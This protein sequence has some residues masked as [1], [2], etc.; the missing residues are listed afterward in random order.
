VLT[1]LGLGE[2]PEA[3]SVRQRLRC[4]A[5]AL[6]GRGITLQ[7]AAIPRQRRAR[8]RLFREASRAEIVFLQR[9]LLLPWDVAV[10]RRY[11]K[12]LVFDFDDAIYLRDREPFESRLRRW[13]FRAALRAADQVIAGN[14]T[15]AAAARS[16]HTHVAVVPTLLEEMTYP[17]RQ[18]VPGRVLWMGQTST[19]PYL[20]QLAPVLQRIRR[21][22]PQFQLEVVGGGQEDVQGLPP[23]RRIPW[24]DDQQ[25]RS[26]AEAHLG[27]APL[28]DNP[29]TRGKC[30]ARLLAY[31][32][33]GVPAI[34]SPVGAQGEVAQACTGVTLADSPASWE[35]ELERALSRSPVTLSNEASGGLRSSYSVAAWE[36]LWLQWVVGPANSADSNLPGLGS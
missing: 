21:R 13:R 33:A 17:P 19:F 4:F 36:S 23:C 29:W 18:A 8:L 27:L 34:A 7:L 10:L 28:P 9:R 2:D 25:R 24:S 11:S 31:L 30:A 3:P 5:G 26:L 22:C 6:E 14:A 12:R 1:L 20:L 32:A 16:L 15:L 35:Q